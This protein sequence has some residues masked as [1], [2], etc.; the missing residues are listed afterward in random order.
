MGWAFTN[1]LMDQYMK[2]IFQM[3]KKM[4]KENTPLNRK[5]FS[6]VSGKM[7]KD[8]GKA[9]SIFPIQNKT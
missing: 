7:E 5:Q 3:A 2:A 6:R 1:T 9:I 8:K 4:E